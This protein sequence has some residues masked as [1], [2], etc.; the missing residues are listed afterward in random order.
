MS[1]DGITAGF[2][3][4]LLL[5]LVIAGIVAATENS[6][7]K[8]DATLRGHAYWTVDNSGESTWHWKTDCVEKP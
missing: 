2:V 4:G 3:M 7:W 5:G 8:R 6:A 1:D